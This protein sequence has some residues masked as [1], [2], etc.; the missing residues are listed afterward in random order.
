MDDDTLVAF[1]KEAKA[2]RDAAP[3]PKERFGIHR[4]RAKQES[5]DGASSTDKV[6]E[7][8]SRGDG[9]DKKDYSQDAGPAEKCFKHRKARRS[10]AKSHRADPSLPSSMAGDFQVSGHPFVCAFF[11]E[12]AW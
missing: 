1:D 3:T 7:Q 11:C 6:Q 9:E 2:R 8:A 10:S 12:K 4:K 5:K